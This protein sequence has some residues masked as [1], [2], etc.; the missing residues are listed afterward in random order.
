MKDKIARS[1]FWVVW[2]RGGIQAL[3]F[4]STIMVARLLSPA[5][6]GVMAMVGI[7]TGIM[8]SIAQM[9][10][11]AAIVQ[12]QDMDEREINDCFWIAN[13][14]IWTGYVGLY[15]MAPLIARWFETPIL[16]SVLRVSALS[17]P[18]NA[19]CL[20][21]DALL[22]RQ[23][24]FDRIA[25]AEILAGV[26][27]II[28]MLTL[29]WLGAGVWA[30]VSGTLIGPL[31]YNIVLFRALRWVPGLPSGGGRIG[32]FLRYS[33]AALGVRIGWDVYEQTDVFILGKIGGGASLGY[34]SMAMQLAMLP[35]TKITAT[36]NGLAYP[37][38]SGLQKDS[39][40]MRASFMRGLRM[41]ACV[42]VPLCIGM[43]LVAHDL[44]A[45]VLT[46][47]WAP[48]VPLLQVLSAVALIRSLV[49]LLPPV[50]LARYRAS[51]LCL[52]MTSLLLVMPVAFY[53]GGMTFGALGI[54]F[55]WL[56]VYPWL[57]IWMAREALKEVEV[58]WTA[59]WHHL[60]PLVW[61]LVMMVC[62]V[63]L[64]HATLGAT[65]MQDRGVR[66][67]ITVAVGALAYGLMI[68]CRG[69]L[70][71]QEI[72]EVL[73]WLIRPRREATVEK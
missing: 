11:G 3:S 39:A 49:A 59:I 60:Q 50:L 17:L 10:L 57:T 4:L 58:T 19:L 6:Y 20:V 25:Y 31:V 8:S 14:A 16:A 1:V 56:L 65:S 35:V 63:L 54:A 33:L 21:P 12:F 61:P 53:M 41:V 71:L 67:A 68:Y 32:Q 40:A 51:F 22:R 30:L 70:I 72:L 37:L 66:L 5:D 26:I 29:A 48:I 18:M 23:L 46:E 24:R 45:V 47:K 52:W 44:V 34:Y 15:I 2:S 9:G 69:G 64:V 28:I 13:A 73:S 38:M 43:M 36:V 42:T 62:C 55:A 7:F 27:T